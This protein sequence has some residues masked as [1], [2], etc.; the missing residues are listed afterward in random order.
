MNSATWDIHDFVF[1][2]G[3]TIQFT[4]PK[5][6]KTMNFVGVFNHWYNIDNDSL[7]K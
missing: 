3:G 7:I 4:W 5:N 2:R 1:F 6:S